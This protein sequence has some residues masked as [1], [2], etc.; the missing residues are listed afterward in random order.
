MSD[1]HGETNGPDDSARVVAVVHGL[2]LQHSDLIRG[3]IR[4]LLPDAD[5]ADD[6]LQETFMTVTRKAAEFQPGSCFPMWVCSIARF[7][8]LET[9]GAARRGVVL[10]SPEAIESLAAA[11]EAL[12]PDLRMEELEACLAGLAPS[13]RRV[14]EL[15]YERNH[16][17]AEIAGLIGWKVEAVYVALSRAKRSL[18]EGMERRLRAI[19]ELETPGSA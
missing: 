16:S 6:V 3:F 13:M 4:G 11:E 12:E 2:F 15:R 9:R 19:G 5:L 17:P 8:V 18:R 1:P 7:K 10:L 14:I